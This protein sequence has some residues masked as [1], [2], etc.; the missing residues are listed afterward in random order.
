MLDYTVTK[1]KLKKNT[2]EDKK[3]MPEISKYTDYR[4]F[5]R[6]Y[7][8]EVKSKN[9][10]FSYEVFSQKAGINSKGFVYNV[11]QGARNLSKS[12]IFK[13][14]Q[15]MNLN[16]YESEYFENLVAFNQAKSSKEKNYFYEKMASVKSNGKKAWKPQIVRKDQFE[17]YSK[18][19]HS[20]IRSLI[21]MYDF[22]DD[23]EWLA[24]KVYPR[25]KPMQAK[26]S[27]AL[28]EKLG[29]IKKQT[30]GIYKVTDKSITTPKEVK[31]L[32]VHNFHKETG[33]LA[34]SAISE[35]PIQ[36]RN[37][38]GMTLGISKQTFEK[39]C[40]QI[41]AFRAKLLQQAEQDQNADT[42]Y[43]L[44]FQFFP[45]SNTYIERNKK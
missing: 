24:K 8:D 14:S 1:I 21:D 12:H 4:K 35:L 44:N 22:R 27:V 5:L 34:L 18:W 11:I 42:V 26:K 9:H 13:L 16:K 31:N 19:Y 28:L 40:D 10:A 25:I 2:Q 36:K 39:M 45:V 7:Y 30:D 43:Q 6:D 33:A 29:L 3:A 37:I 20:V 15:A 32:A 38:T 17:F 23:Y 41:N